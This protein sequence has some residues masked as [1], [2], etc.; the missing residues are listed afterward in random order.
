MQVRPN[1]PKEIGEV[2]Y[3]AMEMPAL[4]AF[5]PFYQGIEKF[6]EAYSKGT[7]KADN[8]SAYWKFRKVQTMAMEDFGKY[9]PIV[10]E[11]YESYEKSAEEQMRKFES[12]YLEEV[13]KDPANAGRMLQEFNDKLARE[14]LDCADEPANELFTLRTDDI[15]QKVYFSNNKS[16]D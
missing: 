3:L 14:A 4:S 5:V 7:D 16:L 11:K 9:A 13:R 8:D 15:Q 1:L 6:P 10:R 12:E 2:T